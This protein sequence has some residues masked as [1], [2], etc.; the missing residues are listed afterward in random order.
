M[1]L[2]KKYL[3]FAS[4]NDLQQRIILVGGNTLVESN[5]LL[6]KTNNLLLTLSPYSV[7]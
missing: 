3:L 4:T 2:T 6:V 7:L 5:S 1:S